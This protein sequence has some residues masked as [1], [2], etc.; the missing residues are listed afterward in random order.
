MRP[1]EN[2]REQESGQQTRLCIL[3]KSL[4]LAMSDQIL[5]STPVCLIETL[6][7]AG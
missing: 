1:G 2:R 6:R 7:Q 5:V 3:V 4:T